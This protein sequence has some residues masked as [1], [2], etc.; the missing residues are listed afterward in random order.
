MSYGLAKIRINQ[1]KTRIIKEN[2]VT[3]RDIRKAVNIITHN[4]TPTRRVDNALLLAEFI[5]SAYEIN[6]ITTKTT[7]NDVE[8]QIIIAANNSNNKLKECLE[9]ADKST[10]EKERF[11]RKTKLP[12]NL[13]QACWAATMASE[14]FWKGFCYARWAD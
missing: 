7:I 2:I 13:K 5:S 14:V 11:C 9:Q 6:R 8:Y 3:R 1:L 10:A 4:F 12:K